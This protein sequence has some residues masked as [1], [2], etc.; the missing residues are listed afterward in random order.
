MNTFGLVS[1]TPVVRF[2]GLAGREI[3]LD[4]RTLRVHKGQLCVARKG[5]L[6]PVTGADGAIAVVDVT[7]PALGLVP[8]DKAERAAVCPAVS[9]A[10]L[11]GAKP[12]TAKPSKATKA[13]PAPVAAP[14]RPARAQRVASPKA[15]AVEPAA[16]VNAIAAQLAKVLGTPERMAAFVTTLMGSMAAK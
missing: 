5:K 4:T 14:A 7:V 1:G 13:A 8:K 10:L 11:R 2:V 9:G 3:A 16:D 15:K 6:A 12:A